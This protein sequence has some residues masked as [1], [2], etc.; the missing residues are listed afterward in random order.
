MLSSWAEQIEKY[1]SRCTR[2]TI[3]TDFRRHIYP[4]KVKYCVY[5]GP[6]RTKSVADLM[7]FDIVL[8]T[9]DTVAALKRDSNGKSQSLHTC[10]WHRLVLD[11][12]E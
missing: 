7:T 11:E 6:S 9:Y 12:G 3:D 8:T 4:Q 5:H 2:L 1:S 10:E